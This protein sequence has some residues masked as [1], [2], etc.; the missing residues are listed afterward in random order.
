MIGFH[1]VNFGILAADFNRDGLPDLATSSGVMLDKGDGT[2]ERP[3]RFLE[4]LTAKG[5]YPH[6]AAAVDLDG[7]GSLDLIVCYSASDFFS[8]F[9]GRG[10]GTMLL[11]VEYAAG[12]GAGEAAGGVAIADLDGDGQ[13]DLIT[14]NFRSNDVSLLLSVPRRPLIAGISGHP[15]RARLP[16]QGSGDMPDRKEDFCHL[17]VWFFWLPQAI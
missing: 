10:D 4:K 15:P 6:P 5:P 12:R 13:P 1:Y 9:R 2:F 3:V 11:S 14:A 17:R 16:K 7:D 8:V